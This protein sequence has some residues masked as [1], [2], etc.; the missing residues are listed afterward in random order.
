MRILATYLPSSVD[1]NHRKYIK[2]T[3]MISSFDVKSAKLQFCKRDDR[4]P[5]VDAVELQYHDE[6]RALPIFRWACFMCFRWFSPTEN[7][8]LPAEMRI[9]LRV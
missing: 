7:V 8:R 1:K 3:I 6:F 4:K 5:A 9:V 2:Q